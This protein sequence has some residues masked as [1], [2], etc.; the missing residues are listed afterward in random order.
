MTVPVHF[1]VTIFGAGF[2]GSLLATILARQGMSV[3]LI[4]REFHPRFAV[5]ESSTPAADLLLHA[6]SE[7]YELDPFIP[8]CRFGSWRRT[9]PDI[10]CGCKRGFSYISHTG[11]RGY[12][13]TP[14]HS[15]ELLVAAS[16]SHDVADTQWYR[17]DVDQFFTTCAIDSGVTYWPGSEIVGLTHAAEHQWD[18]EVQRSSGQHQV[19]TPFVIDASGGNS[20]VLNA[21][22]VSEITD[23]LKTNTSAIF[24]HFDALPL[25]QD[26]LLQQGARLDDFPYP[27]D[28]SAV[29]HLF[30][31]GWLWQLRFEQGPTSCGFVFQ[32]D[33]QE[34]TDSIS[35]DKRWQQL[36][37]SHPALNEL[38]SGSSL[39]QVPGKL[40]QTGRLQRLF[41][42]GAGKDW[43]AFPST[44]GFIDPLHSTGIA[45]TLAGVRRL[46]QCLTSR[47]Q[48]EREDSLR[49]YSE[50]VLRE[51]RHIDLLVSGCYR[52][53]Q[54]FPAFVAWTMLYFAAATTFEKRFQ[55]GSDDFLCASEGSF[56]EIVF[57][58]YQE[59]FADRDCSARSLD[60]L[61]DAVQ[62]AIAEYNSVGLFEPDIPHMYAY[63]AA[64]KPQ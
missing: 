60:Q 59:F 15:H 32:N 28:D 44:I 34:A 52:S 48:T 8:L 13:A 42:T 57:E 10:R 41:E 53:L 56:R 1:D 19:R 14:D 37:T 22:H 30:E 45:H 49:A 24:S 6:I 3:A 51:L 47:N 40:I 62:G 31:S 43:A 9:Y 50:Q 27:V 38:F 25:T 36:I 29:H 63:T 18:F 20:L 23:Q 58:L 17:A 64:E 61:S 54:N 12:R 4:D 5:G 39:S 26:W 2:G 55:A 46:A 7:Q 11:D 21:L 16:A 35:P 33:A